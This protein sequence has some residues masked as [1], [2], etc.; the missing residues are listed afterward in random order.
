MEKEQVTVDLEQ[1]KE[2]FVNAQKNRLALMWIQKIYVDHAKK[3]LKDNPPE[4]ETDKAIAGSIAKYIHE[5]ERWVY[6]GNFEMSSKMYLELM[7]HMKRVLMRHGKLVDKY[8]EAKF[9][10]GDMIIPEGEIHG[11]K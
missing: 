4:K 7:S 9:D 1:T 6:H 11:V 8:N 2:E 10:D 3:C 5:W